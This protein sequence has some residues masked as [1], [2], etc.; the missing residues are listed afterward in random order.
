MYL[1][2]VIWRYGGGTPTP[3]PVGTLFNC[4]ATV[5]VGD[6]VYILKPP[7]AA[8]T[9][10]KAFAAAPPARTE[11]GIGVVISKPTATTCRVLAEGGAN[12]FAGLVHGN[13]YYLSTTIP[14]GISNVPPSVSGE[15][16]QEI[17][18]ATSATRLYVYMD[19]TVVYL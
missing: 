5:A 11:E 4:P 6:V 19:P 12:V 15:M 9:V 10:D 18:I 7:G 13:V 8:D 17:G 3:P 2:K 14:G 1:S 16:M